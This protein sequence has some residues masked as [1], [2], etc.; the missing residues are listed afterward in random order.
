MNTLDFKR[1]IS[2]FA[3]A[4]GVVATAPTLVMAQQTSLQLENAPGARPKSSVTVTANVVNRSRTDSTGGTV[5][6]DNE[7]SQC[8]V[9]FGPIRALGGSASG[10]CVLDGYAL[11][12]KSQFNA[13]NGTH[14][15][16]WA[17]NGQAFS[18]ID[19]NLNDAK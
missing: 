13:A 1:T 8:T 5:V 15:V 6:F 17:G 16:G 7:Y 10:S 18:V 9:T 19:I 11:M 12:A 2:A 14:W 3:V 4:A